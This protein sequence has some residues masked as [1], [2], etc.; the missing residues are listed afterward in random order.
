MTTAARDAPDVAASSRRPLAAA[1]F[2]LADASGWLSRRLARGSGGTFPGRVALKMVP[3]ALARLASPHRLVL[4]SGTNGKTTTTLLLSRAVSVHGPVISNSDG[5]NL[6][7]GLVSTLLRNR[8]SD[9]SWAVLEVDEI[10]LTGVLA[11]T[12]PQMVVLLNLSRD[13]MDRTS[14]VRDHVDRWARA[15]QQSG[16]LTVVANADDPLVVAAV[17][18]GRPDG[19]D[20]VW[21]RAGKPYWQDASLCPSCDS[22]WDPAAQDWACAVCGLSR[23]P[24][25]W[26]LDHDQPLLD[27][28][29][30]PVQLA[31][32]GRA[33]AA[34]ALVAAAAA[35]ALGVPLDAALVQM[36]DVHE[37]QG[38]YSRVAHGDHDVRLLL[39]KNPAGWLEALDQ[40]EGSD[41]PVLLAV[42]AK[43]ADGL[44]PSWLWDVPYER[45]R[46]RAVVAIGDRRLDLAV[47][48]AYAEV[49][50]QVAA[51]LDAALALLPAGPCVTI[52]N[53]TAFVDLRRQL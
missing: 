49:E 11:Q 24:S 53:Y 42:N 48:L 50:H 21:V 7:T 36:Q 37:V 20:T 26:T 32:P 33:N 25:R 43:D 15:L 22:A 35:E 19:S 16:P 28:T 18:R 40:L 38:R 6:R 29:P 5:A 31:L 9:P 8:R 27:G 44:D 34:N 17:Q 2:R 39:A 46:G 10:A 41:E 23:P 51:D 4:V 30:L 52:A 3:D 13:Q 1:A 45:L 47:R 14:E 12:S